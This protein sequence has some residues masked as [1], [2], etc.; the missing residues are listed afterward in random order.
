MEDSSRTTFNVQHSMPLR[1]IFF[2][3]A[4]TLFEPAKPVGETYCALAKAYGKEVSQSEIRSRFRSC[5][6]SSSPLA[7]PG[8]E[9]E[10]IKTLERHWWKDL[11]LR[12]FE[13]YGRFPAFDD[14]FDELFLY[15]SKPE[16]W[17]L[18]RETTETL[19][20]LKS[21]SLILTVVSNFD[22]RLLGIL[23]GLGIAPYFDSVV[24]SS[25]T[26]YAKP[27]QEIFQRALQ[28]HGLDPA[29]ALH[30]GDTPDSDIAGAVRAG[31][32]AI[33]VDRSGEHGGKDLVRV[34]SLT[35]ILGL[36]E[37]GT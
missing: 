25:R 24:I 3:A 33:L 34:E 5:F 19:E 35:G 15:F 27:A 23:S 37:R 17:T 11:V 31:L 9:T 18:Y 30:V 36:L 14:Y 26:G 10:Q 2:D 4:G 29:Q 28:F 12:I 21:R 7:F 13:P 32:K 16:A 6:A 1:A 22:S 8:A 20:A